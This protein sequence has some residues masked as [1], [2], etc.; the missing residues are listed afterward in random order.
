MAKSKPVVARLPW[1]W[2]EL[3]KNIRLS[4][5]VTTPVVYYGGKTTLA[6]DIIEQIPPH[7]TYVE[8]FGGGAAVLL[9]KLPS[10][11]DV[12]NDPGNVSLFFK[13]L[14]DHGEK[15]VEKL[16]LTLYSR[17]NFNISR[18][19]IEQV[20]ESGDLVEWARLWYIQVYMCYTHEEDN[21]S[22]RI[23]KQMN[24]ADA[25]SNHVERLPLVVNR[26]RRTI[27]EHQ[28]FEYIIPTYDLPTTFFYCDPP[29][30]SSTRAANDTYRYEMSNS[31]HEKF[32]QLITKIKGQ[33]IVSGYDSELY[34]RY[35]QGWRTVRKTHRSAIH[36]SSSTELSDR[37]EVLWI[38]EHSHG[39]W[40]STNNF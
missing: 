15:L 3:E 37:T 30:V 10:E 1:Q 22:W 8:V 29:Y 34:N 28:S 38:K 7:T 26:I 25:W 32:L 2:K 33:A 13:V 35:L 5:T 11:N 14:Q 6:D 31:E 19:T 40:S 21:N 9:K 16:Y 36:N 39:L 23:S 24:A 20:K 4:P 27:I 18:S 12:Y 17:E